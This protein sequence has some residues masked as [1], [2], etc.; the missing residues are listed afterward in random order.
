[1]YPKISSTFDNLERDKKGYWCASTVSS[2]HSVVLCYLACLSLRKDP[3]I[4]YS[5]ADVFY[6]SDAAREVEAVF[7]GYIFSD[8]LLALYYRSRWSGCVANIVHHFTVIGVWSQFF[9]YDFGHFFSGVAHWCELTTPFVNQRWFMHE[10]GMAAGKAYFY[11]GITMTILWF[12]TR[13]IVYTYLGIMMVLSGDQW[14]S[15]KPWQYCSI[16]FSY[17]TG[18]LLQYFW[19]YKIVRGALKSIRKAREDGTK[20][21]IKAE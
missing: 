3:Q 11:N 10:S 16:F 7:V 12:I 6:K 18:L 20:K 1:V 15:L 14:L 19:F 5:G 4:A 17:T 2:F 8:L 21:E 9:L 13:I